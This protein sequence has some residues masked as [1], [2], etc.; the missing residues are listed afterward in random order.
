MTDA[1]NDKQLSPLK[2]KDSW[3][4]IAA[5]GTLMS[6][7]AIPIVVVVMGGR[8]NDAIKTSENQMKYIE[9]ATSLIR[10]DPK[11]DNHALRS[12]A[13]DVLTHFSKDVPL[14]EAAREELKK[15][16]TP[17]YAGGWDSGTI[18]SK[19]GGGKIDVGS[20]FSANAPPGA[21]QQGQHTVQ[22]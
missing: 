1:T 16:R 13:I 4:K 6:A 21:D 22:K 15:R 19:R 11:E 17:I 2:K 3:D 5:V 7:I 8:I 9:I 12:W 14:T 10:D 20:G 18:G